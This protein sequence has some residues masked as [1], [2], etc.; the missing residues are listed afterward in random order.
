MSVEALITEKESRVN[1][2]GIFWTTNKVG[3]GSIQCSENMFFFGLKSPFARNTSLS[4]K[5]AP[6]TTFQ[7][8]MSVQLF[9]KYRN[10]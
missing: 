1:N 3:K 10:L 8:L 2:G 4:S 6:V 7:S 5:D 9:S